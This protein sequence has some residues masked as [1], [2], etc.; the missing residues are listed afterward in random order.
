MLTDCRS[1]L[2]AP[3]ADSMCSQILEPGWGRLSL[4]GCA[5]RLVP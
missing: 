2:T 1:D 4:A 3:P 5:A